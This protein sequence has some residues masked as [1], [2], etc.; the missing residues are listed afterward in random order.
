M[1]DNPSPRFWV[2]VDGGGTKTVT[3]CLE[4]GTLRV[5]GRGTAGCTNSNSVGAER[6]CTAM[7]ESINSALENASIT[8]SQVLGIGLGVSGADRPS[9]ADRIRGW[10]RP[11][12]PKEDVPILVHNDGVIALSSGTKGVLDGVVVIS[13]TGTI[14]IGYTK[15][16]NHTRVSGWGPLLGDDGSGYA[17]G[18]A[19]LKAVVKAVDGRGPATAL[20]DS[21]LKHINLPSADDLIA[22]T[23]AD[24]SWERFAKLATLAEACARAGDAVAEDILERQVD[25]L[26]LNVTTVVKKLGMEDEAFTLVLAGGVLT[27]ENSYVAEKMQKKCAAAFPQV[28]ITFP[29]LTAEEAAAFL[30]MNQEHKPRQEQGK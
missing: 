12:F 10:V 15:D 18:H 3:V 20:T 13:G 1:Q 17:I 24:V 5:A 26:V 23:Y 9:D 27:H 2:G 30:V 14:C 28:S 21:L 8:A 4:E 11:L 25:Q 19:I 16:G 6:A 22:W 7:R 29:Q